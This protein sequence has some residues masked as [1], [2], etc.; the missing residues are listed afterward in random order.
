MTGGAKELTVHDYPVSHGSVSRVIR[1]RICSNSA[2]G[3]A[4]SA[5]WKVTYRACRTIRAPVLMRFS[6]NVVSD[7]CF[8][9]LGST[10]STPEVGKAVIAGESVG[11]ADVFPEGN[12]FICTLAS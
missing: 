4:T 10:S 11:S 2:F 6:R 3:T 12:G 1:A 9:R 5:N 7:Q 8:T